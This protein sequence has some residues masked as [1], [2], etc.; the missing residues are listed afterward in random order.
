MSRI[1]E[2]NIKSCTYYFFDD[3]VNIKNFDP[4]RIKI[5]K[6]SYE[7]TIIDYVGYIT[8]KN[9][10][11]VKI[12]N[13]NPLHLI[14]YIVESYKKKKKAIWKKQIKQRKQ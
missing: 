5:D 3:I 8:T 14:I 9:L 11:Y 1:K 7:S 13:V 2:T 12:N 10:R 4:N 6:K